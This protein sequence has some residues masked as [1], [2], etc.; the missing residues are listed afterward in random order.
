MPQEPEYVSLSATDLADY[1]E[2]LYLDVAKDANAGLTPVVAGDYNCRV[3]YAEQDLEK[4]W[5]PMITDEGSK[6]LMTNVEVEIIDEGENKG[7]LT[8]AMVSTLVNRSGTSGLQAIVQGLGAGDQFAVMPRHTAVK[9]AEFLN[10][11]LLTEPLVGANWDWDAHESKEQAQQA[12]RSKPWKLRGMNKFPTDK[13]GNRIPVAKTPTGEQYDA[14]NYIRR[15]FVI[16]GV[17][18]KVE[19][20]PDVVSTVPTVADVTK[21]S[22]ASQANLPVNTRPA[23]QATPQTTGAGRPT[24]KPAPKPV[25]A[26]A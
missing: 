22:V 26:G 9:D 16:D 18:E 5:R 7:R 15:W 3:R 6:Y 21:P 19:Q 1:D 17:A 4:R 23:P 20:G 24:T 10:Q 8:R 25:R 13:D 2:E 12:G 11:L 14:Y